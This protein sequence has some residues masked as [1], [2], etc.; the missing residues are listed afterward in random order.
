MANLRADGFGSRICQ[1]KNERDPISDIPPG[2][3]GAAL[4]SALRG[5]AHAMRV[6][7]ESMMMRL[8][9]AGGCVGVRV[10]KN[11]M[12]WAKDGVEK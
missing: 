8:V 1:L 3:L 7:K 2:F 5:N 9:L 11:A 10:E 4:E 6:E 12:K